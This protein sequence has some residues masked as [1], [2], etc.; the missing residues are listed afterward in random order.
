MEPVTQALAKFSANLQFGDLDSH[1]IRNLK[2][3]LLDGIGCGLYGSRL[4]WSEIVNGFIKD[5][6]GREESTLWTQGF[7]GPSATVSLGLGVMIHSFDYDDYHNAK[8]HP[9]AVVIPAAV[10]LGER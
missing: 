4:P 7:K 1:L 3:Y 6:G 8:I 9:G 5:L 2:K 10:A